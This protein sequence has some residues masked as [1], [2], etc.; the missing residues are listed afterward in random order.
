MRVTETTPGS[1]AGA[2]S[3]LPVSL[4]Y[5]SRMRPTKGEMSVTPA[6]AQAIAWCMPKSSVRLQWMPSFSRT[7]A[8]RMPSQVEE[9][10][11]R[12]RSRF[13]PAVS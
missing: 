11:M 6:S 3:V 2:Y 12:I 7:S 4:R 10:L 13:A 9:I 5:Q 8:A 1:S